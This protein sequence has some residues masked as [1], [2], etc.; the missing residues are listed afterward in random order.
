MSEAIVSQQ[1]AN[2]TEGDMKEL[3]GELS[4]QLR[5]MLISGQV[6]MD[7]KGMPVVLSP[8][9]AVLNVVRQF[10]KDNNVT[11]KPTKTNDL[12]DLT[13]ELPFHEE[14]PH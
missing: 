9:P 7:D 4:R 10:L 6:V 8:T 14:G 5:N 12:G 1:V 3:H 13:D 11:C 2:A